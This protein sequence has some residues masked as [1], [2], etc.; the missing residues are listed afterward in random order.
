MVWRQNDSCSASSC[1]DV[2]IYMAVYFISKRT[3][4]DLWG[5][6]LRRPLRLTMGAVSGLRRVVDELQ[7][8]KAKRC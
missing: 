5:P 7:L 1:V 2:K 4:P 6:F 8:A 3:P